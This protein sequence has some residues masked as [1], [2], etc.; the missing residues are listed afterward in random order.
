MGYSAVGVGAVRSFSLNL[1]MGVGVGGGGGA[2]KVLDRNISSE[3]CYNL[4]QV[5]GL[6]LSKCPAMSILINIIFG[7]A[8]FGRGSMRKYTHSWQNHHVIK[9]TN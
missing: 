5:L 6:V 7:R 4:F 9:G 3:M 1:P 2:F 8:V